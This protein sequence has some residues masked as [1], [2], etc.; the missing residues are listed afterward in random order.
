MCEIISTH[1][2]QQLY[3]RAPAEREKNQNGASKSVKIH[4]CA[5]FKMFSKYFYKLPSHYSITSA[6]FC[7][8]LGRHKFQFV[9]FFSLSLSAVRFFLFFAGGE[10][11]S[12]RCVCFFVGNFSVAYLIWGFGFCCLFLPFSTSSSSMPPART[13]QGN[14][15]HIFWS[16][17][18]AFFTYVWYLHTIYS[19]FPQFKINYVSLKC[20]SL[21]KTF[22]C[23]YAIGAQPL[24]ILNA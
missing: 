23:S 12:E 5:I 16:N 3:I 22:V 14:K 6:H 13:V 18:C 15:A 9:R 20:I 17:H 24:T 11:S 2:N 4:L 1:H 21:C 7:W 19:D 8:F 10:N